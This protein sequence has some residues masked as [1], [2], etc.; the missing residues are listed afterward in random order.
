MRIGI[1]ELAESKAVDE[2]LHLLFRQLIV[3]QHE[4]DELRRLTWCPAP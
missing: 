2:I 4:I 3:S 1:A